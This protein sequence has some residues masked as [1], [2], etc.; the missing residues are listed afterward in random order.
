MRYLR[1]RRKERFVSLIAVISLAGVMLGTFALSVDLAVMSGFE[2]DLHKRLLAF[3]P[4][5]TIQ[6]P[7][8]RP[9]DTAALAGRIAALPG[10]VGTA[11][12]VSGQ[13]LLASAETATSAGYVKSGAVMR[14]VVAPKNPVLADLSHSLT[15]NALAALGNLHPVAFGTGA[16]RREVDLPAVILGKSLAGDLDVGIGD[17]VTLISPTSFGAAADVPRLKRFWVGGLLHSGMAEYDASLLFVNLTQAEA[18]AGD[19]PQFEHGWE[20]RV[21]NILDAPAM[22]VRIAALLGPGY[23]VSDWTQTNVGLFSGLKL[24]TFTH[25][26]VLLLI[27]LVAAFNIVAT[28]VMVVMERRKEV[29]ILQAMGAPANAVAAIFLFEGALLGLAGTIAGVGTGFIASFL[30]GKYHLIHLPPD[31]FMVSAVPARLYPANFLLVA[32]AAIALC[33]AAALYPAWQAR[34]LSPV[35]V[36]RYE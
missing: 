34:S 23:T 24:E 8:G 27:V 10:V 20:V 14:G 30:I 35:E 9:L 13:V 15:A 18:L 11:P 2:E 21:A 7:P 31:V 33:I 25:F 32:V 29:A 1:A 12:Y 36:L 3:T 19:S 26:L 4:H 22:R 28:L 6:S 5:L 17:V 16:Q